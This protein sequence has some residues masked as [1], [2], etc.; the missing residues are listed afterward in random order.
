MRCGWHPAWTDG[1]EDERSIDLEPLT[2][3][4]VNVWLV[5]PAARAEAEDH[6]AK[7]NLLFEKNKVGVQFDPKYR[8]VSAEAVAII[9]EGF[10]IEKKKGRTGAETSARF[11]GAVFTSGTH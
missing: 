6:M 8:P 3:V 9:E 1:A 2:E 4:P 10:K 11:S 5:N 7:A